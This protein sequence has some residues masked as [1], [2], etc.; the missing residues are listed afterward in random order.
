MADSLSLFSCFFQPQL[1]SSSHGHPRGTAGNKDKTN[2][3]D[4]TDRMSVNRLFLDYFRA[5]KSK[6]SCSLSAATEG[7]KC[8]R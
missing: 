3:L 2:L 7:A 8:V 5:T 6:I 4:R 1:R